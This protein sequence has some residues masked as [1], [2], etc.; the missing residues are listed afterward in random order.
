M[1]FGRRLGC[2]A[3]TAIAALGLG[4]SVAAADNTKSDAFVLRVLSNR[5]DLISDDNALLG[6]TLPRG[7]P[8]SGVE[9]TLTHDGTDSDVT[10]RFKQRGNGQIFSLLKGLELG[11]SGVEVRLPGGRSRSVAFTNH[12]NGGPVFSGPQVQPWFCQETA[13]DAQCNEPPTYEFFYKSTDPTASGLQPYDPESPPSDVATTTTDEGV[14]APFIVREET[15]Y[16][17]R[18]QYKIA[19]LYQPDKPWKPWKPQPQ[20]NHKVLI[21]HG[22]SCGITHETGS[23][24]G[25]TDQEDPLSRGFVVMSTALDNAGHNC[26]IATQAESLV[27]AKERI[28]EQHGRIRYTIGTGCSGGALTQQQ[29][30]NAYPGIYQGILPQCSYPDAI[31]TGIQFADYHGL[32]L[33]LQSSEAI[34][35]G[36]TPVQWG[37]ILGHLSGVNAVAADE[38]FF[39]NATNPQG[40]CVPEDVRY[41]PETNPGGV[42]C[43][44]L[45]YM[46]NIFGPRPQSVWSPME[47][48]AGKGFAGQPINNV[49]VQYGLGAMQAAPP[50]LTPEQFVSMNEDGGGLDIDINR[51]TERSVGDR[52]A[53]RNA[54]RSGAINSANHMDEVAIIDLRGPDPAI[55]HDAYRSW[56]LRARLDR[57]HGTHANQVI[58]FGPTPLLGSPTFAGEALLEMD[59]WLSAVEQDKSNKPLSRKILDNKPADLQDECEPTGL[60]VN[61]DCELIT[62]PHRYGTPRTVA[63]DAITTDNAACRLQPLEDFDYGAISF[64]EDQMA[65]LEATFPTGVC[66]FSKPGIGQQNTIA[67]QT[68]QR[69]NGSVIYGGKSLGDAPN[70]SGAGWT[71]ESFGGWVEPPQ[72]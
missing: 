49:G 43:S 68:Y 47:E 66:D 14:E 10:D 34:A 35:A 71:S 63:G 11:R 33:Y 60:I 39:K 67:W 29:V 27:M 24:P 69:A 18:D 38:A 51:T 13:Q 62:G 7:Q 54:Y 56:E 37:P 28:V 30:A 8:L 42:R 65:R 72:R 26:N 1:G 19:T 21:T 52:R 20:W 15:G 46:I 25:V 70:N 41:H 4:A 22:A 64:T 17:D 31:S 59:E 23:A 61:D 36:I 57:E 5:A 58:W 40:P 32:L 2:A 50:L 45:D 48:A 3:L 16:Q 12:P 55:A 6:L 53:L 9:A 44:I